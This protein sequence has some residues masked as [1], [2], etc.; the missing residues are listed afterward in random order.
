METAAPIDPSRC[1]LCGRGNDCAMAAGRIGEPCW[2]T[3]V[4]VT[5]AVL[6]RI[7]ADRRGV[8]CICAACVA[9]LAA[10]TG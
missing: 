5:T 8:A 6:A 2:C 4:T 7:P 1:P 3:K 9:R 10:N